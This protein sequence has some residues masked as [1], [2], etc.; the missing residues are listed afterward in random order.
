[1][2]TG[3]VKFHFV[4]DEWVYCGISV[5]ITKSEIWKSKNGSVGK[6]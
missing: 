2:F 6:S 5:K 4:N 1:M 3:A